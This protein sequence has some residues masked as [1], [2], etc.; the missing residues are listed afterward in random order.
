MGQIADHHCQPDGTVKTNLLG[1]LSSSGDAVLTTDYAGD[2]VVRGKAFVF[3]KNVQIAAGVTLYILFDYTTF[4]PA[5]DESGIVFVSPPSVA[6]TSGPVQVKVY[7]G[8]DYSGGSTFKAI[9]PNTI[10]AKSESGTTFSI[11]PTG[12]NKGIV[13]L[14]YLVGGQSQ[15]NNSASGQTVGLEFFIRSNTSKTLVEIINQSG[16]NITFHNGHIFYEI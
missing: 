10:A 2:T 4:I 15:G 16:A 9:N 7:R 12:S 5:V 14:E 1:Q 11:G 13:S 6:T 3:E 8:T